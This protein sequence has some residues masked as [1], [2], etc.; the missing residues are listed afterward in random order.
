MPRITS[1]DVT[2]LAQILHHLL[3]DIPR[4]RIIIL[5]QEEKAQDNTTKDIGGFGCRGRCYADWEA[6]RGVEY[7]LIAGKIVV[8]DL[9][10]SFGERC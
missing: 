10:W 6:L 9:N 5:A 8:E 3:L 2:S 7:C 1:L 4:H